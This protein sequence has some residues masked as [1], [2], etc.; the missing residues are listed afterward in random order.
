MKRLHI[1]VIAALVLSGCAPLAATAIGVSPVVLSDAAAFSCAV[2]DAANAGVQIALNHG[3][4]A[5]A[6]HFAEASR[7]AGIGCAW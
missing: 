1:F 4:A 3:N 5:W 6:A 2:Q 7:I